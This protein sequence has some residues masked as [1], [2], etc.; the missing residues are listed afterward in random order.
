MKDALNIFDSLIHQTNI[1]KGLFCYL[2]EKKIPIDATDLL[3]WQWVLAVSALDKYIHDIV[4]IGM[5]QEFSG[6]RPKTEKFKTFRINM[7]GYANL[8]SS[9]SPELDFEKEVIRQ[10]SFLAFQLPDKIADALSYIWSEK[11][12]WKEIS[13]NM[14]TPISESDLKIKLTNIVIRRNQIVHE[15]DCFTE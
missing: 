2:N 1:S 15:G 13:S 14:A 3:R 7:D 12:K 5:V 10:H 9:F 4:C 8:S 11:N 6:T